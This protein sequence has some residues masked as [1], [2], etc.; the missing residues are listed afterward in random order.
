M[1]L[2]PSTNEANS[3]DPYFTAVGAGAAYGMVQLAASLYLPFSVIGANVNVSAGTTLY[4][5]SY[6]LPLNSWS[7][8]SPQNNYAIIQLSFENSNINF[9]GGTASTITMRAYDR[10]QNM[11][12]NLPLR[13]NSTS[14]INTVNSC[15]TAQ[16]LSNGTYSFDFTVVASGQNVDLTEASNNLINMRIYSVAQVAQVLPPQMG[17]PV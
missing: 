12:I 14:P 1:S 11:P 2:L 4:I 10:T 15:I 7:Y 6:D 3:G 9:N 8:V 16:L 17:V 5:N 13:I